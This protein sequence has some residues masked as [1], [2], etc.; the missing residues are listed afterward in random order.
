ME[1]P[2]FGYPNTAS[3]QWVKLLRRRLRMLIKAWQLLSQMHLRIVT[4]ASACCKVTLTKFILGSSRAILVLFLF[5]ILT[6]DN[7]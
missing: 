4:S 6:L 3:R 5:K 2:V 7:C 1:G